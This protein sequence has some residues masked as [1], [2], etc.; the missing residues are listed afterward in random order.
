[1]SRWV[2]P[3]SWHFRQKKKNKKCIFDNWWCISWFDF[4]W[5][6]SYIPRPHTQKDKKVFFVVFFFF[7]AVF[8][9]Y[10]QYSPPKNIQGVILE[11]V[12]VVFVCLFPE[13]VRTAKDYLSKSLWNWIFLCNPGKKHCIGNSRAGNP[14]ITP[15][16]CGISLYLR[17]RPYLSFLSLTA[18]ASSTVP[19]KRW[20]TW[21]FCGEVVCPFL[22]LLSHPGSMS[23]FGADV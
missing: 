2:C 19:L 4:F 17:Q 15:V 8:F 18:L 12:V 21:Y 16:S 20:T 11:V 22:T 6:I 5:I 7:S 23:S 9:I 14:Q 3:L 1:M 13:C 10:H